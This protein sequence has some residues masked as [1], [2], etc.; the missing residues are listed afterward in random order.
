[1]LRHAF[2]CMGT[3]VELVLRA[4]TGAEVLPRAEMEFRRLDALLSRFRSDSELSALNHLGSCRVGPELIEILQ[5][6]LEA[7]ERTGG[8]FDPTIHDALVGAGYDRT[9][10]LVA[11]GVVAHSPMSAS[12]GGEV[13]VDDDNSMVEIE[14]GYRL[15]LGG[16]AKG[17]AADRVLALLAVAGPALV[18]A[19]GDIAVTGGPWTI[20]VETGDGSVVLELDEGSVATSGRDR[21]RWSAGGEDAH[22]LID[23]TTGR[24]AEGDLLRVTAVAATGMEAEVLATALFLAGD[25]DDAAAEADV[26]GVPAILV[27]EDGRTVLTGALA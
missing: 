25:V 22:H 11:A 24:P 10:E 26:L 4:D 21:R 14:P 1:M 8:R 23:P 3:E 6:A 19:G 5:A 12:C 17:Y 16:I 7:R 15:D 20:G 27:A 18:D 2:Q 9:F 13:F